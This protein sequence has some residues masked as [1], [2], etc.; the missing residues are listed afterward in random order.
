MTK[1]EQYRLESLREFRKG[2][3]S[4]GSDLVMKDRLELE[5]LEAKLEQHK[6]LADVK[7][8]IW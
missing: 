2:W 5:R 1:D 7:S 4:C 6:R 8:P 3:Q